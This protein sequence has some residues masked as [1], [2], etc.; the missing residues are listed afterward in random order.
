MHGFTSVISICLVGTFSIYN[1]MTF[2][3][4]LI[5][6]ILLRGQISRAYSQNWMLIILIISI[7]KKRLLVLTQSRAPVCKGMRSYYC[8]ISKNNIAELMPT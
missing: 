4:I 1:Y 8:F 3:Y 5:K 2:L 6:H 7:D